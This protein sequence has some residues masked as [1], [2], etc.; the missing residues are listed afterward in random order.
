LAGYEWDTAVPGVH[1]DRDVLV[2]HAHLPD[3]RPPAPEGT[4]DRR[5]STVTGV[6]RLPGDAEVVIDVEYGFLH[7]MTELVDGQPFIVTDLRD[8]TVDPPLD[9]DV[10]R[11]DPSRFQVIEHP[12]REQSTG[13]LCAPS[14]IRQIRHHRSCGLTSDRSLRTSRMTLKPGWRASLTS[15]YGDFPTTS[16]SKQSRSTTSDDSLVSIRCPTGTR[17]PSKRSGLPG[18]TQRWKSS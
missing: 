8:L 18:S 15:V 9:E 14:E 1:N 12:E 10:F 7:R 16:C 6:V 5:T 2:V 4:D 13:P 3:T 17:T 11:I